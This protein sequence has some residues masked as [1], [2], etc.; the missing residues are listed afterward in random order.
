LI[1]MIRNGEFASSDTVLFWH[2]GGIPA[3]FE[4]AR[5]LTVR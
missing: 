4:H 3:L 2:T 5:E 1:H